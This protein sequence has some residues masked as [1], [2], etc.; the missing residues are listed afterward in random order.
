MTHRRHVSTRGPHAGASAP[1]SVHEAKLGVQ[2]QAPHLHQGCTSRARRPP[3]S[4]HQERK[5]NHTPHETGD[6]QRKKYSDKKSVT[7]TLVC[8]QRIKNTC[9]PETIPCKLTEALFTVAK[10]W[11]QLVSIR[12]TWIYQTCHMYT[13]EYSSIIKRSKESCSHY[14]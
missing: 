9:S 6:I 1:S 12:N 2:P 14:M 11:T 8:G 10:S 3:G 5:E 4:G 7:S 13:V